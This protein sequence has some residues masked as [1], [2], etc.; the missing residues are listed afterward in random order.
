MNYEQQRISKKI[1][2]VSKNKKKEEYM[3]FENDAFYTL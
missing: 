3:P 2:I 1:E